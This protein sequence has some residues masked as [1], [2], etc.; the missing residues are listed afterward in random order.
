[1]ERIVPRK[2][3]Q[4]T[5]SQDQ[6]NVI[7]FNIGSASGSKQ[8][9]QLVTL[10]E[11]TLRDEFPGSLDI[12]E[13]SQLEDSR[14]VCLKNLEKLDSNTV[15]RLVQKARAVFKDFINSPWY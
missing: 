3:N 11:R 15:K 4:V 13:I 6:S 2:N 5:E 12:V 9:H 10:L 1:M 14:G 8:P 7:N